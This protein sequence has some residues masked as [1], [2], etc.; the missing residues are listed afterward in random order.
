MSPD[1]GAPTRLTATE[2]LRRMLAIVPWVAAQPDG[3]STD[4]ICARFD[5][6]RRQLQECLDTAF[7]VGLH[8]YTPDALIDVWIEGDRVRLRLP[9]FFTR[10]LRLTPDQ[11]LALLAAGRSLVKVPG[12][13]PDGPLA[14]GLAK[15]TASLAPGGGADVVDVEL[16]PSGGDVLTRLQ[17]AV[18]ERRQ[19]D[20]DYYSYGRDELT[21]RRVDPWR[22]HAEQGQWYLEAW[23]HS[24]DDVRVFRLDRVA[25][26]TVLDERFAVPDDVAHVTIFRPRPDDPRITVDLAPAARWVADQY[27]V[28]RAEDIDDG[29]LRVELA[30]V[31][32]PWLERLLVRLGPD[33]TLVD[34]PAELADVGSRAAERI[35][36]RY[37]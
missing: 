22:V 1:R 25:D 28:E 33:A 27:P 10:P 7:M 11:A 23:C 3:A 12:N 29:G 30:V 5:L 31:A 13:D 19:V 9:D 26:A 2:R 6:D 24:S 16:G 8:P 35:L 36:R 20:L 32:V 4:E 17:E 21:H 15:L 14:R 34:P 18:A 37:T